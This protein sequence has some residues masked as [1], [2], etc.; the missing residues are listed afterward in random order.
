VIFPAERQSRLRTI[1]KGTEVFHD[2]RIF[3]HLN[4]VVIFLCAGLIFP[5]THFKEINAK[6]DPIDFRCMGIYKTKPL[7]GFKR[8]KQVYPTLINSF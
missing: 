4:L 6:N 7:R 5:A 2:E 3:T 1:H 8:L